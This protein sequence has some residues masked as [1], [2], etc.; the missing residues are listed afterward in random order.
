MNITEFTQEW[1]AITKIKFF[2]F[3]CIDT[4]TNETEF[5]TFDIS[6]DGDEETPIFKGQHVA[7]NE[8]DEQSKY[9]SFQSIDIDLDFSLDEHL[10]ALHD[11]CITAILESPFYDLA[12]I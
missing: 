3:E 8:E 5:L 11:E 6:I 1:D 12:A 10:Q 9:I 4:R 2:E 7:L